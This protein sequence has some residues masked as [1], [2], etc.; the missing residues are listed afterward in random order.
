M[1][2]CGLGLRGFRL[3][4]RIRHPFRARTRSTDQGSCSRAGRRSDHKGIAERIRGVQLCRGFHRKTSTSTIGASYQSRELPYLWCHTSKKE[5]RSEY[6]RLTF[7]GEK[8]RVSLVLWGGRLARPIP[9]AIALAGSR[10]S[11]IS[12]TFNKGL[13]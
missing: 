6:K 10:G 3:Q 5:P 2:R 4:R 9:I 13:N 7:P 1:G 8:R 12:V 11:N